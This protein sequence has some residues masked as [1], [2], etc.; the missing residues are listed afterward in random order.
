MQN[1]RGWIRSR[2]AWRFVDALAEL[3]AGDWLDAATRACSPAQEAAAADAK[4]LVRQGGAALMAWYL[5]DAIDTA[6]WY[7]RCA[8]SHRSDG[9]TRVQIG[10]AI[11]AARTAA[12]AL[13]VRPRLGEQRFR[14]LYAPFAQLLPADPRPEGSASRE[15]FMESLCAEDHRRASVQATSS[16]RS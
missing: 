1:E 13:L 15:V 7:G 8:T 6:A 9:R 11:A 4:R 10:V 3:P 14:I 12:L 2:D 16:P 5:N